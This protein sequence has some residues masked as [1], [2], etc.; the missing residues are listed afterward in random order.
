MSGLDE[1]NLPI[2]PSCNEGNYYSVLNFLNN[3]ILSLVGPRT[4]D[5]GEDYPP[6][7]EV[8]LGDTALGLQKSE[9]E[10]FDAIRVVRCDNCERIFTTVD[11][12]YFKVIEFMKFMLKTWDG[13]LY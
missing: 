6:E 3:V 12:E 8:E 9:K 7:L 2:C 1:I 4:Y 13:T 10:S 5:E 11:V